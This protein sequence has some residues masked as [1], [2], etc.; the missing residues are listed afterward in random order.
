MG[1][2]DDDE[3]DQA[4]SDY[5]VGY[6]RPPRHSRFQRGHSGNPQGRPPGARDSTTLLKRALLEPVLVKGRGRQVEITKLR[7]VATQL[8]NQALRGGHKQIRLLF[9]Y[10][11]LDRTLTEIKPRYRGLTHEGAEWLLQKLLGNPDPPYTTGSAESEDKIAPAPKD[12]GETGSALQSETYSVGYAKPPVH[13]RFQKGQ[14]GNPAGRPRAPRD[15]RTLLFKMLQEE[16]IVVEG[17][18]RRAVSKLEFILAQIVNKAAGG[19][20]GFQTLLL[21]YMPPVDAELNRG[22]RRRNGALRRSK[23]SLRDT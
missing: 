19:S 3:W 18:R 15:L 20:V 7:A 12:L 17:G 11:G 8:V 21:E 23:R 5:K 22:R 2:R 14:S 16:A 13:T 4:E 1:F 6:C 9:R 10:A